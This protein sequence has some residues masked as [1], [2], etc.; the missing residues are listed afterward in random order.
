MAKKRP[1]R[2]RLNDLDPKQW[3]KFQKSWFVHDPPPRRKDVK[4]HPAK[5][6][7]TLVEQFVELF[8]KPGESV[9]DPMVGTGSTVIAALRLGRSACGI[10]LSPEWAGIA[11]KFEGKKCVLF[12]RVKGSKYP[13]FMGI[14]W[15]RDIVGSLFGMPMEKVPFAI[16]KSIG[17][18]QKNKSLIS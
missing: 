6:P 10:E 1:F 16:A 13:V 3:I 12:E 18:W 2:N 17:L 8:T 14:L 5:F 7:E 9:F 4:L 15:N 11:K